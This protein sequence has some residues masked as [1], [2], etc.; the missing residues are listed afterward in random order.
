LIQVTSNKQDQFHFLFSLQY[1]VLTLL[2]FQNPIQ[3]SIN[4]IFHKQTNKQTNHKYQKWERILIDW[5]KE[6]YRDFEM[7]S[8]WIRMSE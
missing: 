5:M 8:V 1:L 7:C 4:H 2:T 3:I 6:K